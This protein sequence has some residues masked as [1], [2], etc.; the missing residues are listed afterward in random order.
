MF[1]SRLG[2]TLQYDAYGNSAFFS[3]VTNAS[4]YLTLTS[5]TDLI[6]ITNSNGY[7][8]EYWIYPTNLTQRTGGTTNPGPGNYDA[9]TAY[10][11][12]G[13]MSNTLISNTLA[14]YFRDV[15]GGFNRG[16][17][18][19]NNA[20][21]TNTWQNISLVTTTTGGNTTFTMYINGNRQQIGLSNNYILGNSVTV[22]SA[23]LNYSTSYPVT[24]G[25]YSGRYIEGYLDQIRISNINR[26]SGSSYV[27]SP[28]SNDSYTQ[29][30]IDCNGPNGSTSFTDSSS[31]N[32][33]ITNNSNL[34]TISNQV[35]L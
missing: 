8:L 7:T 16:I 4:R 23:N 9:N 29:L 30:L 25:T 14:F 28:L 17:Y 10:W 19:A 22:A 3:S 24:I 34:V 26:Y 21:I 11:S 35:V 6:N 27:V 20:L 12:F 33:T 13:P 15:T 2:F 5:T 32:Y 1:S 31:F 18:T